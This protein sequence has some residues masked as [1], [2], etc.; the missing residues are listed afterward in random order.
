MKY[1]SGIEVWAMLGCAKFI[2]STPQ[3]EGK[4]MS[5]KTNWPEIFTI[6]DLMGKDLMF[7]IRSHAF[8]GP[9][10]MITSIGNKFTMFDF[11]WIANRRSDETWGLVNVPN[12]VVPTTADVYILNTEYITSVYHIEAA[13]MKHFDPHKLKELE[14]EMIIFLNPKRTIHPTDPF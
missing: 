5:I 6:H 1:I 7:R 8:R 3:T 4:G 9:I 11:Q 10:S 12:L 14:V 13:M 2:N